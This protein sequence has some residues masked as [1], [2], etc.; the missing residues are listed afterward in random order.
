LLARAEHP[1][2]RKR[3]AA[4][5][6]AFEAGSELSEAERQTAVEVVLRWIEDPLLVEA[7]KAEHVHHEYP[8][9]CEIG[10]EIYEG[11]IDLI[12]FD[13]TRWTIVDYKTGPADE[14]RHRRQV[15]IYGEA[16]R[17][18]TGAPVRLIVLEVM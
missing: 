4:R 7:R 18:A 9:L 1:V 3:L 5:A 13:G 15:A 2:D 12:W 11:V 10:G 6:A 8:I 14:P 16:V 17:R